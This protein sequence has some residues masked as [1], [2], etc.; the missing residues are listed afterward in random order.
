[1]TVFIIAA[2]IFTLLCL[3]LL[4]WPLFIA[5]REKVDIDN[6]DYDAA[7]F[8]SQLREVE[9]DR[10]RGNLSDEEAEA[11]RIEIAR[12]LLALDQQSRGAE[13][14]ANHR[15]KSHPFVAVC[16][17]LLVC[18][19]AIGTY[20]QLGNPGMP[21][22]PY[23]SRE[24]ERRAR[25]AMENNQE[26]IQRIAALEEQAQANPDDLDSWMML[27][28]AYMQNRQPGKAAIAYAEAVR[29]DRV[30]F[31]VLVAYAEAQSVAAQ[32][33][34][35]EELKFLF[36]EVLT[37]FPYDPRAHFYLAMHDNQLGRPDKAIQRLFELLMRSDPA[38][39]WYGAIEGEYMRLAEEAGI[40]VEAQKQALQ[41][42]R[43]SFM[44]NPG[45]MGNIAEMDADSRAAMIENMVDGLA[46]RLQSEPDDV[47]GW[48]KLA[49]AATVL[50][51]E[52]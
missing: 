6:L 1:M 19:G 9:S 51:R 30:G 48:R 31:G 16:L 36:E 49:R 11:A 40:D 27:G 3:V 21:D 47:G 35:D 23:A 52:A 33:A 41:E 45:N 2:A 13:Q 5:H 46:S 28:D 26:N 10:A 4:L 24:D 50:G 25:L 8:K 20:L 34:V 29:V 44:P 15:S 22:H 37:Y 7:V 17:A 14:E 12:R 38:E 32:G 43:D 18:A 42:R 39:A